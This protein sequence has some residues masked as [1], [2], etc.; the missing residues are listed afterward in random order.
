MSEAVEVTQPFDLYVLPNGTTTGPATPALP[1]WI[2]AATIVPTF[3][4]LIS[5]HTLVPENVISAVPVPSGSPFGTSTLPASV[6]CSDPP[7][8]TAPAAPAATMRAT[9]AITTYLIRLP[10]LVGDLRPRYDERAGSDCYAT[11]SASA[12]SSA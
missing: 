10:P 5:Q 3:D 8:R 12:G 1:L 4:T 9:S 2:W 6:A 11:D 7:F